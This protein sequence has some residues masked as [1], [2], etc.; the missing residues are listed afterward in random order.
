M[1]GPASS[2]TSCVAAAKERTS[3]RAGVGAVGQDGQVIRKNIDL[4]AS[5]GSWVISLVLLVG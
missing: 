5:H 3:S 2:I 4:V 1:G